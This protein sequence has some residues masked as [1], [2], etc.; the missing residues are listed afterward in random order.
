MHDVRFKS[1]A[2]VVDYYD[3]GGFNNPQLDEGIFPLK[4][5][6]AEKA[7]LVTFLTEGLAGTSYLDIEP[8]KLP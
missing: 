6:A 4:L 7:D 5:T 2:E 8:P 3:K 1:L